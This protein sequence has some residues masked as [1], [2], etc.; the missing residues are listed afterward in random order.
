MEIYYVAS[1]T[2]LHSLFLRI[3]LCDFI[4]QSKLFVMD[5]QLPGVG[6][7]GRCIK[8]SGFCSVLVCSV[9]VVNCEAFGK[10]PG[11]FHQRYRKK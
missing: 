6:G 10:I 11:A 2:C 5:L 1:L 9:V 3:T 4:F 7:E 8:K